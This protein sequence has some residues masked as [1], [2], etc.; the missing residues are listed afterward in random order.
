MPQPIYAALLCMSRCVITS[1]ICSPHTF[2]TLCHAQTHHNAH[3]LPPPT[4]R[5]CQWWATSHSK[6]ATT[7]R[8]CLP[9]EPQKHLWH[10]H[11]TPEV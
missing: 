4:Y 8:R 2:L 3:T 1:F 11:G 5:Q 9:R 6:G 10:I 7:N